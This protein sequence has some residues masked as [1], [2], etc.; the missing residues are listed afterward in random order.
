[1]L[2]L[3]SRGELLGALARARR[4][5]LAAYTLGPNRLLGALEA[6]AERGAT[7]RVNLEG[8]PY[9][10]DPARAAAF[11][12]RNAALAAQLRLHGVRVRLS[13]ARGAPLHL[14][15][16]VVDSALFLDDRNWPE[17]GPDTILRT[18]APRDVAAARAAISGRTPRDADLALRK[19]RALAAEARTIAHVRG[20]RV[21][22][23]SESFSAS[24][25]SRALLAAARRGVHVRVLVAARELHGK[26][27]RRE[28]V[29]LHAL[30]AAGAEVRATRSDEKF[31]VAGAAAWLGSANASGGEPHA[32]EWGAC[33]RRAAT[34]SALATR[35]EAAWRAA[36]T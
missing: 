13:A 14:K 12:A 34:V 24:P 30:R 21:D 25:V 6:A 16:A 9:A 32:V 19:D 27:A 20:G 10:R 31:C 5:E 36:R 2:R 7:V 3:S 11:R 29:A 35:F 4:V 18:T 26:G 1:M 15:A 17:G 28:L 22:C 33:T 8:A 23:E